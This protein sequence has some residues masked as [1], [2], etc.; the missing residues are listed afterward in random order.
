MKFDK[1]MTAFAVSGVFIG[2]DCTT[3]L[4]VS[5]IQGSFP[6]QVPGFDSSPFALGQGHLRPSA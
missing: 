3:P 5:I 4:S 2:D 6:S 1:V